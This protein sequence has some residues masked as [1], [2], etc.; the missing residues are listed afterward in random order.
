V[1]FGHTGAHSVADVPE[2]LPRSHLIAYGA[3]LLAVVILGVR[4]LGDDS[5]AQPA[6]KITFDQQA[7]APIEPAPDPRATAAQKAPAAGST[8]SPAE[9]RRAPARRPLA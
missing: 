6:A 9:S 1:L 2:P 8:P 5:P 7:A 3:V 4:A